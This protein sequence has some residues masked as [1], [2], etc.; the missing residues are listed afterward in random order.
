M[1]ISDWSSDVYS[2][3]LQP[4]QVTVC[5]PVLG[6]LHRRAHQLAGVALQIRLQPFEQGEGVRRRA[7]KAPD[8]RAVAKP[9]DLLRIGLD[10]R[11]PKRHLAGAGH[12]HP[13]LLAHRSDMSEAQRLGTAGVS[14][15]R[16]RW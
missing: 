5:P 16:T 15:V 4:P 9:P 13:A 12:H 1:R 14:K 6:K 8:H 10:N 3:D 11:L 2:S 7:R